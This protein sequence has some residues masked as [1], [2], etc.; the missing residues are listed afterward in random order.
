MARPLV[1]EVKLPAFEPGQPQ[2]WRP[3]QKIDPALFA[4]VPHNR[5]YSADWG[6]AAEVQTRA[7]RE[8][9]EREAAEAKARAAQR[10][11]WWAR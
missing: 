6:L 3:P 8:R 5:H 1:D 4:P 9:H 7:T 11:E 10:G 2:A